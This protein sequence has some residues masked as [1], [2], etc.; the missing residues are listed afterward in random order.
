MHLY[1]F[2]YLIK[3]SLKRDKGLIS[4]VIIRAY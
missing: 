2:L 3:Y 1:Y 4:K